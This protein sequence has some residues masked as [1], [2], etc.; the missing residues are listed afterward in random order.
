[1]K[2]TPREPI[3]LYD[4]KTGKKMTNWV[5]NGATVSIDAPYKEVVIDYWHDYDNGCVTL[6]VG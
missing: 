5:L 4:K 3:F 1:L 2:H 6:T